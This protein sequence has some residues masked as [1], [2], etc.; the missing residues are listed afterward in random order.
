MIRS[1][2]IAALF[3]AVVDVIHGLTGGG[4][5]QVAARKALQEALAIRVQKVGFT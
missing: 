3:G 4:A 2:M 1:S 5:L